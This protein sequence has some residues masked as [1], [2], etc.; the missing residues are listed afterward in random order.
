MIGRTTLRSTCRIARVSGLLGLAIELIPTP[1]VADYLVHRGDVLEIGVSGAPALSRR[2][3]VDDTGKIYLPLI[4]GINAVGL[5][6]PELQLKVRDLMIASNFRNPEVTVKIVEYQPVYVDG[7]VANPG[8]YPYHPGLTVRDVVALADG[9]DVMQRPETARLSG[10]LVGHALRAARLQAALDGRTE[11]DIKHLPAVPIAPANLSEIIAIEVQRLRAEQDDHNKE[12]LHL[13]RLIQTTR[14]EIA[15]LEQARQEEAR[16]VAQLRS[17]AAH[18]REL[19]QKGLVQSTRVLEQQQALSGAGFRLFDVTA[20]ATSA[21]NDLEKLTRQLQKAS[22]D[23]R[24]KILQELETA[25]LELATT[26]LRTADQTFARFIAGECSAG[27]SGALAARY[28]HV[29]AARFAG[30]C[31]FQAKADWFQ[32]PDFQDG[33]VPD[34]VSS[35]RRHFRLPGRGQ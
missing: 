6:L 2:V 15:S 31:L 11:I 26:Q 18:T 7:A 12:K 3:A 16:E 34:H 32:R 8:S 4:Q 10:E 27:F 33:Q 9:Y 14:E 17:D 5:S 21:R 20:R 35:R 23:R 30:P 1:V 29:D 28:C 19:L 25:L 13:E 22:D 24:L